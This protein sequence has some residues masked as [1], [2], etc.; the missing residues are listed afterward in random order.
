MSV[1][2]DLFVPVAGHELTAS[3]VG[4]T[5]LALVAVAIASIR[6]RRPAD[7]AAVTANSG[8]PSD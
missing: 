2:L 5:V 7:K 6:K 4:G 1:L 8:S 3:T